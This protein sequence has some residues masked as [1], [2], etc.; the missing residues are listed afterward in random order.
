MTDFAFFRFGICAFFCTP[1]IVVGLNSAN[2]VACC[3]TGDSANV[4][5]AFCLH[6]ISPREGSRAGIFT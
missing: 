6:P 5:F 3:G 1:L 2:V 4:V